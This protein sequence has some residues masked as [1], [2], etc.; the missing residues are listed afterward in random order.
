MSPVNRRSLILIKGAEMTRALIMMTC[1]LVALCGLTGCKQAAQPTSTSAPP[2]KAQAE[3]GTPTRAEGPG[4]LFVGDS[5]TAGFGLAP[6]ESYVAVLERSLR[7]DGLAHLLRNAGV[8]GD[9][10]AGVKRRL[11][12]LLK[13]PPEVMFLC[14][15]ANDGMRGQPVEALEQNLIEII[16]S[17]REA[18]VKQ[19][20]MMGMRLP[21]NYG[22]EYVKRFEA[23]YPAVAQRLGVPLMPFLLEGVAGEPSLNLSDGIHPNAAGHEQIARS[24]R[25]FIET[26]GLLSAHEPR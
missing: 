15:G 2:L 20:L 3:Q 24:M 22:A 13:R 17:A 25:A 9:T 8:S 10:S 4:W 21:P 19:V 5:L 1:Q 16:T 26:Q 6:D 11:S 14:I 12:W 7:A 23:V 18:G